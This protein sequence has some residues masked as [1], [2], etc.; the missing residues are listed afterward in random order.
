MIM[1]DEQYGHGRSWL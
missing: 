1:N